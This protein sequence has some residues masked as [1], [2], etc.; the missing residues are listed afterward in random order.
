MKHALHITFSPDFNVIPFNKFSSSF[1]NDFTLS[2]VF[3]TIF[4]FSF[5]KANLD[6]SALK[7]SLWWI[8]VTFLQIFDKYRADSMALEPPPITVTSWFLYK[9]PSQM[10]QWLIPR[11]SNSFSFSTFKFLY[12]LPAAIIT[13]LDVYVLFFVIIFLLSYRL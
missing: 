13:Y 2:F 12:F 10:A 3:I 7:M 8:R 11:C 4:F 5:A 6:F 1:R 9:L